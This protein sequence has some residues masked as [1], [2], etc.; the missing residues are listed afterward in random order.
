[1]SL[2]A[3]KLAVAG[4]VQR[5]R[6]L[7][8][9]ALTVAGADPARA[10]LAWFAFADIYAR[11]NNLNEALIGIACAL[12]ADSAATWDQ[13]W[14]ENLL[15]FRLFRDLG[16]IERA[17]PLLETACDALRHLGVEDRY[18]YRLETVELQIGFLEYDRADTPDAAQLL[19]LIEGTVRNLECVLDRQDEPLPA[20]MPLASL[21]GHA[22]KHQVTAPPAAAT[23]ASVWVRAFFA[24]GISRSIAQRSTLSAGHGL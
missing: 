1:L 17:K 2:A 12:A 5:A 11:L 10:R 20:T 24:Y 3:T 13:I 21:L 4:R 19:A 14:Y 7:A 15:I 8:E 16:L 23:W 18:A 9:Q 6:D 22:E